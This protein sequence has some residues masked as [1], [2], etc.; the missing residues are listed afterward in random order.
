MQKVAVRV[1]SS[2]FQTPARAGASFWR[3]R[4]LK[5]GADIP[6]AST[7]SRPSAP[8]GRLGRE[9]V[10]DWVIGG[11][12]LVLYAAVQLAFLQG[13]YPFDS[14]KYFRTAVDFPGVPADIWT[15]RIG[16]VFPVRA[17]VLLF[18]PSEA[19]LY[20]V[21]LVVGLVLAAA[22]YGTMLLLFGD[23]V[24]AAAASLVTVLNTNYLLK[25]SS[26]FPDTTATAAFTRDSSAWSRP[27]GDRTG[28]EKAG[29][30]RSSPSARACSSA[31][32]I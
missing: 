9:T 32:R 1:P 5:V 22:V 16:V 14:A 21:P 20:A 25:S 23:R 28:D 31:G 29:R 6:P 30:R 10:L 3:R 7:E 11:L 13:P 4:V 12:V 15:L 27:R 8:R 24:L 18:G 26:I 17:A 2:A 19:A